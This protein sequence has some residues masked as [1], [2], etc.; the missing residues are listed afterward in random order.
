[1]SA[2]GH[3]TIGAERRFAEAKWYIFGFDNVRLR[4]LY[5]IKRT[6]ASIAPVFSRQFSFV[7]FPVLTV[8]DAALGV[9]FQHNI[10]SKW[11]FFQVSRDAEGG[12]PYK[13]LQN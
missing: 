13:R 11:L 7:T 4:T 2:C 6:G 5:H 1:M 3:Y 12:V 10:E 8:G 9:P